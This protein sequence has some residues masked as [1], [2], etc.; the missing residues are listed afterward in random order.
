MCLSWQHT[1]FVYVLK[2]NLAR[3]TA[4]SSWDGMK[5]RMFFFCPSYSVMFFARGHAASGQELFTALPWTVMFPPCW[6]E[7]QIDVRIAM[8]IVYPGAFHGTSSNARKSNI[9]TK[10]DGFLK[11]IYLLSNMFFWISM[12]V[13][14]LFRRVSRFFHPLDG[15][16]HHQPGWNLLRFLFHPDCGR[17]GADT[18]PLE[19]VT[20]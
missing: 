10:S 1:V 18:V 15:L 11:C 14:V 7:H 9:D 5:F 20:L 13:L 16:T 12:L 2:L 8:T 6:K 17:F 19:N 4:E 3:Q